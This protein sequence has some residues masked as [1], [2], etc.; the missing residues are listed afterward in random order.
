M[1]ILE[2]VPLNYTDI[3]S[4]IS[5]RLKAKGY[6][7]DYEGSNASILT[8]V[9]SHTISMLNLNTAFNTSEML[10]STASQEKNV[11]Y[12]ARQLGFEG[13][14][15]ISYQYSIKLICKK[16]L[17][18]SDTDN[19]KRL[20]EV[21]RYS[22]FVSGSK[23][24]YSVSEM[25]PLLLSNLD[26]TLSSTPYYINIVVKEGTL[27]LADS[28][29]AMLKKTTSTDVLGNINNYIDIPLTDIEDNGIDILLSYISTTGQVITNEPWY[30]ANQFLIDTDTNMVKRF[31]RI[32]DIEFN[33]ARLY[34]KLAGIG[35]DLRPNTEMK[36]NVIT[37]SGADGA[38]TS[39][40][41]VPSILTP[42]FDFV[43][44]ELMVNGQAKEDMES[45]RTNA[46]LFHNSA[47]RAVTKYDYVSMCNRHTVVKYSQVWGG[48]EEVPKQLGNIYF[49]FVP[50]ERY[51]NRN[52]TLDG[53]TGW[54]TLDDPNL[55]NN[56]FIK[57]TELYSAS[58]DISGNI[59][60]PG[61]FDMLSEYSVMTM[62]FN[63]RHPI[64]IDFDYNMS[65]IKY[66]TK[67][68]RY[69]TQQN[70]FNVIDNYF[71][72]ALEQG[73]CDYFN[74]NII[75][76][77]DNEITDLSGLNCSLVTSIPLYSSNIN[78]ERDNSAE[79]S[80]T[81]FLGVPFEDYASSTVGMLPDISTNIPGV[82]NIQI[83]F[84]DITFNDG[85]TDV[86]KAEYF[87]FPITL[88]GIEIGQYFV[89]QAIRNYIRID[90]Y[91]I[92]T[93]GTPTDTRWTTSILHESSFNNPLV[94]NLKYAND[95]FKIIKNTFPRLHS[96]KFN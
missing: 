92:G 12:L 82:G 49:S 62:Q 23:K 91:V 72:D 66:N 89:Q 52:F 10:L 65:I 85:A 13:Q 29:P 78:T 39:N 22:E 47:N 67:L 93:Y 38:A 76:K 95:N 69:D 28:Y 16:D 54:Y 61:V 14:N 31:I 80:I 96:I 50:Q 3:K 44:Q 88:D 56:N 9:I 18:L 15:V 68:S 27:Y 21:P 8:D 26:I 42:K 90:L 86:S 75:K 57:V 6:D 40:L 45:V 5:N 41:I 1:A 53:N 32:E 81:F 25:T 60:N 43:N 77:V 55:D 4:D 20:Y 37:S 94:L 46:P 19:V 83:N 63:Y 73:E 74:S 71:L 87:Y 17:T 7:T 11:R 84:A 30:K 35:N 70:A 2:V 51:N 58:T 36:F 59:I 48:E 79:K 24:Y 33:T 34:F 64:Y